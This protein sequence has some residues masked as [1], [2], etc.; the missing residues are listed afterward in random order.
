[1][2][3]SLSQIFLS[4]IPLNELESLIENCVRRVLAE[5]ETKQQGDNILTIEE[6]GYFLNLKKQ[7]IYQ[8]VSERKIP[9]MKQRK[10]LY[11]S[12]DDL[13]AWLK[14]SSKKTNY[15]VR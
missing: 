7:T 8:L 11:F 10:K 15:D 3:N 13:T 4:P 1:M 9:F 2:S 5:S 14:A 12:K 6:A